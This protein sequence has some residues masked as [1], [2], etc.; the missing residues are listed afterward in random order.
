M[1]VLMFRTIRTFGLKRIIT[2]QMI[3]LHCHIL[4]GIDDGAADLS[5]ALAMARALAADGVTAVACTPH[6]LPGLYHNEGP[7]IRQAI[8]AL[9][10]AVDTASIP[11]QLLEGA[12]V[13]MAPNLVAGLRSGRVLSLAGSRYVLIEPPHHVPPVRLE[14]VF[15]G[16]LAAGFV[17]ILTHPERLSWIQTHY[18][19]IRRLAANGV[20]LQLTAGSLIGDFG[21]HAIYWGE[22]ML[23][24]RIVHILAT[25]SHNTVRRPPVLGRGREAA[26]KI[27]GESEA[28]HLVV[29]RPSGVVGNLLPSCLPMPEGSIKS[30]E[31]SHAAIGGQHANEQAR[32]GGGGSGRTL[33]QRL[34][35]LFA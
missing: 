14:E 7:Q 27:V 17:P 1:R 9:Q 10:R 13:H 19:V 22:R 15:F 34:R 25:D 28:W 3:D 26:G 32:A 5:E 16:L 33:S 24:E 31:R 18:G 6:I 8:A 29:T 30:G 20:W 4:P 2:A 23:D 12:D 35:Q 21:R 11:L